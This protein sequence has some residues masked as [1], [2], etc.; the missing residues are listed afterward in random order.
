MVERATIVSYCGGRGGCAEVTVLLAEVNSSVACG[1]GWR[2]SEE[3]WKDAFAFWSGLSRSP[4]YRG[5]YPR[6][7]TRY[8]DE[9]VR[10]L[11]APAHLCGAF[12]LFVCV[13]VTV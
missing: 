6:D 5:K 8:F 7:I 10:Q 13:C 1:G 12:C 3:S 9:V 2:C 4:G 11:C